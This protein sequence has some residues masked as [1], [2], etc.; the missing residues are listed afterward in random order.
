MKIGVVTYWYGNS[1][2]G[3]IMQCWALQKYLKK[4]GHDPYVIRYQPK[5]AF[6]RT[7]AKKFITFSKCVVSSDYRS[8]VRHNKR[9]NEIEERK[10]SERC[11][12]SF[13]DSYLEMSDKYYKSLRELKKEP[14]YADCYI[15]GSDQIWSGGLQ[16][17]NTW[18][19]YLAFGSPKT[20]RIAYAPSFGRAG[21]IPKGGKI[22]LTKALSNFDY[23][24]CRENDAVQL[25]KDLGYNAVKVE[26]PTLLL[27][28]DDYFTLFSDVNSK[29]HV[30]IYSVNMRSANDIYIDTIKSLF[31]SK[32]IIVTTASGNNQ[33]GEIFGDG[34]EYLYATPGEWLALINN[35]D[36]VITSSFHGVVFSI[37]LNKKF[38]FVPIKGSY[39]KG[40]NRIIDLLHGLDLE[41]MI[42][43]SPGDYLRIYNSTIDWNAV[44]KRKQTLTQNSITFLE[45]SLS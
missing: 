20:K 6:F 16:V 5:G 43:N 31:A 12:Q 44:N 8:K 4:Q 19:Y 36:L 7:L 35:S 22:K 29:N 30:F 42:V 39:S 40:N 11:F 33:S 21:F 14:P 24:S 1:N 18:G 32:K 23:I 26:D 9:N 27:S 38:A 25:C 34:V 28:K 37:I 3:M 45:K 15:A 10:N 2:Y 13:R 41:N 17:P